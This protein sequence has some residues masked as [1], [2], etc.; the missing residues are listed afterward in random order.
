MY[1]C[2]HTRTH[3]HICIPAMGGKA[4]GCAWERLCVDGCTCALWEPREPL[5]CSSSLPALWL[6]GDR[7]PPSLVW[8][9]YLDCFLTP[10][11][12]SR[13]PGRSSGLKLNVDS[14]PGGAGSESG[15]TVAVCGPF[16][17]ASLGAWV[18]CTHTMCRCF[19]P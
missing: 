10:L 1:T 18:T 8:N 14:G 16:S 6:P 13:L 3:T 7:R 9:C 11:K 4:Q 12:G 5:L 19:Q 15:S 2:E 17:R